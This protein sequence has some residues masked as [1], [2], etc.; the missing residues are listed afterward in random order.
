MP[1][2]VPAFSVPLAL[3]VLAWGFNFVVLKLLYVQLS[4]A[5]VG[6]VRWALMLG[7]LYVVCRLLRLPS[8]VRRED[9]PLVLLQGCLSLGIYMVLFLEGMARTTPGEA[10]IVLATSPIFTALFAA[11]VRQER[12]SLAVIAWA[13]V[14]FAGVSLV[15]LGGANG[16]QGR[17]LGDALIL[18][19]SVVWAVSTVVSKPLVGR[20][21]PLTMLTA[22][23]WGAAPVLL[24]YGLFPVL[25][26]PWQELTPATWSL[27]AY[28]VLAAGVLG[29]VGFYLGVQQIGATGAMLY[30]YC[31][32]P[33]AVL[34]AWVTLGNSLSPLQLLGLA[35]VLA[36]VAMGNRARVR[37][38]ERG[39]PKAGDVSVPAE[40][41]CP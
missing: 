22:S 31:V 1:R 6:L 29:F 33:L 16:L 7:G 19:S 26:T 3:T 28:V 21:P 14:A 24:V 8:R 25:D 18:A 4:P 15:A 34:F 13:L 40:S 12:L 23:M 5:A 20:I 32:S 27:M 36:G 2:A 30:Q 37:A 11:M 38:A 41:P 39:L 17:I 10:A 35:V 9:V